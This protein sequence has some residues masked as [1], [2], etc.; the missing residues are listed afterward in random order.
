M[1]TV[2]MEFRNVVTNVIKEFFPSVLEINRQQFKALEA[3]FVDRRDTFAIL[4]TGF[5]KS[6]IF[7]AAPLIAKELGLVE[8]PLIIVISPLLAIMNLKCADDN[9]RGVKA[10]CLH[11][12]E[13]DIESVLA[14]EYQ[15]IYGTLETWLGNIWCSLFQEK[16]FQKNIILPVTDEAHCVPKW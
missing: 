12:E 2:K 8:K 9:R 3:L 11:D 1:A 4:P 14:C 7:Q 16:G 6:L 15:I 10:Y 13:V 5:G